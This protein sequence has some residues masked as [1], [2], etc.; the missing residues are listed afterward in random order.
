MNSLHRTGDRVFPKP[1]CSKKQSHADQTS[2]VIVAH[3]GIFTDDPAVIGRWLPRPETPFMPLANTGAY[4]MSMVSDDMNG[5]DASG[6]QQE[7]EAPS[8]FTKQD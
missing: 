2:R 4:G 7:G 3:L 5:A 8:G 1:L 6:A